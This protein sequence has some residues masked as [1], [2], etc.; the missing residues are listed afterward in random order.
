M[1][2]MTL[3]IRLR[4]YEAESLPSYLCRLATVNGWSTMAEFLLVMGIKKTKIDPDVSLDRL[5][6]LTHLPHSEFLPRM[7]EIPRSMPARMF[8]QHSPRFCPI[9]IGTTPYVRHVEHFKT[10]LFCVKHR[11][12]RIDQCP[13]CQH[14]LTWQQ[15][16]FSHCLQCKQPWATLPA[17]HEIDV[18]YQQWI[19][20]EEGAEERWH[21]LHRAITRLIYPTDLDPLPPNHKL[22]LDS[23]YI[24]D[25]FYL[26]QGRF[27]LIWGKQCAE[28]RHYLSLFGEHHVLS[29]LTSLRELSGL[30]AQVAETQS[31]WPSYTVHDRVNKHPHITVPLACRVSTFYLRQ[32]LDLTAVQL[33]ILEDSGHFDSLYHLSNS[34]HRTYDMRQIYRWFK[35]RISQDK[36]AYYPEQSFNKLLM[37]YGIEF[38][39]LFEGIHQGKF[40]ITLAS[41]NEQLTLHLAAEDV[42]Q[43]VE[44]NEVFD[45]QEDKS[46]KWVARRLRIH[47]AG[48][49]EMIRPGLFAC[50]RNRDITRAS[51]Q[52]VLVQY[53]SLQRWCYLRSYHRYSVE[54]VMVEAQI[55]PIFSSTYCTLLTHE[56]LAQL[57]ML[58]DSRAELQ[59]ENNPKWVV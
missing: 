36:C 1:S 37:M 18:D 26:L 48:M 16:L 47:F 54:R 5:V 38:S 13:C 49:K 35:T 57:A 55:I 28:D 24:L 31:T 11:C 14:P 58:T 25:A 59:L 46:Q 41:Y 10:A 43:F 8:Y 42:K 53:S 33:S 45:P 9:C 3:P 44:D 12:K 19:E 34:R 23:Q 32:L 7:E 20:Q 52:A 4:P 21:L 39:R 50:S 22:S 56:Q 51:L 27:D 40:R 30:P 15:H 2:A 17:N 6:Q 29:P